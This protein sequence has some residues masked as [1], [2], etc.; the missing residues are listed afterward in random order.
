M[1]WQAYY[2]QVLL[3]NELNHCKNKGDEKIRNYNKI[4]QDIYQESYYSSS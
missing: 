1:E 4:I 3:A 2:I